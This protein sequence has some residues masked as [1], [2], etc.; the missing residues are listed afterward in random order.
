[1]V[2]FVGAGPG[3]T[4][5]ITLRGAR[6]LATADVV[7]YAGSLVNPELLQSCKPDCEILSSAAMT[8]DAV[9]AV[10][11]DAEAAGKT[12]VRLHTG[13]PSLY[14][15]I[16]EQ[17]DALSE[18]GIAYDVTPGVSS[19]FGAAATLGA[20]FTLPGV[21]QSLIVTRLAGRTDVPER[22]AL[23]DLARHGASMALFL[24]SGMLL[25]VQEELLAGGCA[26][27]TPAALVYKATW[28]DEKTIRCT[29]GTLAEAGAAAGIHQT[30][31]VLVGGFLD[32][33][34]DKS[35]LYDPSFSTAFRR[36]DQDGEIAY[37][38][39]T[40]RGRMLA[41]L[42]CDTLGGEVSCTRDGV[43]LRDWT[44]AQFS[45]ARALVY[46]GATGIA[47]RAVAPHL[48]SKAGDPAVVAVD[49]SGS[50]AIPLASGH[51]GGA[52]ELAGEIA[53]VCGATPVI[54]TATDVNG[55]F[56]VDDWA[57]T[58]GCAVVG[59]ERIKAVSGKLLAGGQIAVRSAFPIRGEPPEGVMLTKDGEPDVWVDARAHDGLV[60]VPRTLVLGVGC[61]RGTTWEAFEARFAD[62][63]RIYGILPE[64]IRSAATI[65]LKEKE[66]GLLTFCARRGWKMSLFSAAK[67]SAVEGALTAS[68][69]VE[70]VT[71]VDN[72]C[73]RAALLAAGASGELLIGKFAGEGI[74]FAVSQNPEFVDLRWKHG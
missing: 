49:E 67:L 5:L 27:D 66:E 15:A 64:A 57:R 9:L 14:G 72:V 10:M 22:E 19:L 29:V 50:F 65:D 42:L 40:E 60:V 45:T 51:L 3:A 54:T 44:A 32:A 41:Q 68:A 7:I 56:A 25:R 12:T 62:F 55:A 73:E 1:M 38:A 39:F 23:H 69:F 17:M 37:L 46:V 2:H 34:Y 13:D 21:S 16:R 59:T 11:L 8:L 30:A 35:K 63:C 31:L 43:S 61:R 74:T 18:R 20:E 47:V 70:E 24:S 53:R 28:P 48:K 4:D 71:G 52:N 6:L 36:G 26:S 58:Q 33:P